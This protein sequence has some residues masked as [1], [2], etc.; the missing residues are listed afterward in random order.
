MILII[1]AVAYLFYL[2][3]RMMALSM[4]EPL[5]RY[6]LWLPVVQQQRSRGPSLVWL[7]VFVFVVCGGIVWLVEA[8][9]VWRY[10]Y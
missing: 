5:E 1:L 2:T 6:Y 9:E 3:M 10:G 4:Q 8:A 7:V